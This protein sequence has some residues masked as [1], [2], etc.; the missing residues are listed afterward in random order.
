MQAPMMKDL[1]DVIQVVSN[2]EAEKA[3]FV[4]CAPDGP[5]SFA[6]NIKTVCSMCGTAIMHRPYIPKKPPKICIQCLLTKL[7]AEEEKK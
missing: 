5:S 2:E 6:D 3:E 4:L 1:L 7:E